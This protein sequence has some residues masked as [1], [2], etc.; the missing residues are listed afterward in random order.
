MHAQH[1]IDKNATKVPIGTMSGWVLVIVCGYFCI[2]NIDFFIPILHTML[3]MGANLT[4]GMLFWKAYK[5]KETPDDVIL[6]DISK[7]EMAEYFN[8]D[9]ATVDKWQTKNLIIVRQIKR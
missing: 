5:K 1:I 8:I 9:I 2:N 4:I 6:D 3:F 7:E